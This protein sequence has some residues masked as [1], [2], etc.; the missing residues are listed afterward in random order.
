M[1]VNTTAAQPSPAAG[2]PGISAETIAGGAGSNTVSANPANSSAPAGAN[3]AQASTLLETAIENQT[4]KADSG[5]RATSG[6]K[7]DDAEKPITDFSK[8]DLGLAEGAD[9]ELVAEFGRQAVELGLTPKQARS[10]AQW[11][12]ALEARV[13][14]EQIAAGAAELAAEWGPK[15]T[16][17][18]QQALAL[19]SR[20]DRLM[21]DNRFSTALAKTGAACNTD[22]V[23]ALHILAQMTSEDALGANS[24]PSAPV[25]EETALE[26]LQQLFRKQ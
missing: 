10:L 8:V 14:K 19:V 6:P 3:P 7:T 25:K 5:D 15:A 2:T 20:I 24:H 12:Q 4:D 17:N 18:Q 26:G 23:R 13:R 16:E 22:F 11:Q 9:A 21:G 1:D